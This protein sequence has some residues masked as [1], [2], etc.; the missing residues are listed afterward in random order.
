MGGQGGNRRHGIAAESKHSF[1][2]ALNTCCTAG[3][4]F[5][6]DKNTLRCFFCFAFF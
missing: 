3:I 1:Y 4:G 6:N 5:R 2:I